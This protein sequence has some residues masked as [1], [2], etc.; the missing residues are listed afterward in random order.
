MITI[1]YYF[2]EILTM[3]QRAK[4]FKCPHCEFFPVT[5]ENILAIKIGSVTYIFACPNCKKAIPVDTY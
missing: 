4:E 3:T 5:R 2:N 1:L